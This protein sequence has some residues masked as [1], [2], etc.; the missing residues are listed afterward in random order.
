MS[1]SCPHTYPHYFK[2]T[3]VRFIAWHVRAAQGKVLDLEIGHITYN[4]GCIAAQ[5]QALCVYW[6]L[7]KRV[8]QV[9]LLF[10]SALYGWFRV[11]LAKSFRQRK[12]YA[13]CDV[14]LQIT[15]I[16]MKI[17]CATFSPPFFWQTDY[18]E[19]GAALIMSTSSPTSRHKLTFPFRSRINIADAD[20]FTEKNP[21]EQEVG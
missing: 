18:L 20:I 17:S 1:S 4:K 2:L 12:V 16:K 10:L 8:W 7:V 3:T 11:K 19:A 14:Q 13:A 21:R 9:E 6:T 15:P 5:E